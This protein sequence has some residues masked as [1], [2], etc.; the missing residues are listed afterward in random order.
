M[1]NSEQ[2]LVPDVD[3]IE[4]LI[5]KLGHDSSPPV[6]DDFSRRYGLSEA[7]GSFLWARIFNFFGS[8][9]EEM[10]P[11]A[12]QEARRARAIEISV[13]LRGFIVDGVVMVPGDPLDAEI[14]RIQRETM[15]VI[16]V[17]APIGPGMFQATVD[18]CTI[19]D[20]SA[21]PFIH[22][23]RHLIDRGHDPAAVAI[24]RHA[25]SQADALRSA[26][27]A[28]AGL[29]VVNRRFVRRSG[30]MLRPSLWSSL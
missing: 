8:V 28:A 24:M 7:I 4:E 17:V 13:C 30:R 3:A 12:Y 25:G 26:V 23:C 2:V 20:S 27:G 16:V 14:R 6:Y 1:G 10:S 15:E 11:T 19:V 5:E 29:D 18:G 22:A 9:T 21:T